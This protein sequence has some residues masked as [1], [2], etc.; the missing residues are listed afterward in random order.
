VGKKKSGGGGGERESGWS[1]DVFW[2][3]GRGR[4]RPEG[5]DC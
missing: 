2:I 3:R 5:R 4:E 1:G